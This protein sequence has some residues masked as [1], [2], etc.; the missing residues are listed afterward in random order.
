MLNFDPKLFE[1]DFI[2]KSSQLVCIFS[3]AISKITVHEA[4]LGILFVLCHI[5]ERPTHI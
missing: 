5:P 3:K 2:N 1:I 4:V